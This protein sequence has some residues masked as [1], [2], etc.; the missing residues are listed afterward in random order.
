MSPLVSTRYREIRVLI[1][2]PYT[3]LLVITQSNMQERTPTWILT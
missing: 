1:E 2:Q 3:R